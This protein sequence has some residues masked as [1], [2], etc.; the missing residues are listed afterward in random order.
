MSQ[1]SRSHVSATPPARL[2]ARR[3]GL[4]LGLA[5]LHCSAATASYAQTEMDV[6]K[7][8]TSSTI[9]SHDTRSAPLKSD[10]DGVALA[11]GGTDAATITALQA[12]LMVQNC[13]SASIDG[14]LGEATVVAIERY[15]KAAGA[16]YTRP[17]AAAVLLD[18]ILAKPDVRCST[19][20]PRPTDELVE[21]NDDGR[22]ATLIR[23]IQAKLR[24]RGCSP[25][26]LDGRFG[27][28]T[29]TALR[30]A[31]GSSA[32]R[33]QPSRGLLARLD[34]V[35]S[36]KCAPRRSKAVRNSPVSKKRRARNVAKPVRRVRPKRVR[37]S[38]PAAPPRVRRKPNTTRRVAD[39]AACRAYKICV[40]TSGNAVKNSIA[41]ICPS[42]PRGC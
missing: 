42:R 34:D 13:Y 30:R 1:R 3:A 28:Q 4:I 10:S 16:G 17:I 22:Q 21:Q 2:L 37:A 12:A 35:P 20:P 41:G 19:P 40:M 29:R 7:P 8:A 27:K 36:S 15:R 9:Q 31:L 32:A 33:A 24:S 39:P 18:T 23:A 38:R 14:K 5:M 6:G 25:G 11:E 26:R